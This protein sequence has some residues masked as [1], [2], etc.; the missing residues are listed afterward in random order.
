MIKSSV[1]VSQRTVFAVIWIPIL[2]YG[3]VLTVPAFV[4]VLGKHYGMSGAELGR[5]A[6]AEWLACIT[7]TYL[8][9]NRSIDELTRWVPWACVLAIAANVAGGILVSHVPLI[10]FHPLSTFGAGIAYGYVLKVFHA[11]GKQQRN[12]GIFLA[13]MYLSELGIFQLVNYLT[14]KYTNA[15][16]FI[17]YAALALVA[18]IVSLLT[19]ASLT[20]I[21]MPEDPLT[22]VKRQ[23][24]LSITILSSIGAL[25]ISYAAFGMMWPFVQLM[26]VTRGFSA[27]DV[28]N[29]TSAYAITGI[30]G[31]FSAA[32]LPLRV[33]RAVVL[34]IALCALLISI[35]MLYAG[36]S[37]ILFFIG[38]LIF[39]FY[40]T[41]YCTLHVGIIARADNT[42]RAIVLCGVSP[43]IGAIFGSFLGGLLI[44]GTNYLLPAR[45]GALLGVIGIAC[46][47][48]TMTR[49]KPVEALMPA[50]H[51]PS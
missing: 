42:G 5:L 35:Y 41:F 4:A 47:L 51:F 38:C 36:A 44:Q 15:A 34:G 8:T 50:A 11:S 3:A 43:S 21:A 22:G 1:Q 37:Y 10:L 19:R 14:D 26:G 2:A 29:G 16:V 27:L 25:G 48:A 40:W 31:A 24:R 32:L 23:S 28:T 39:G 17:V 33:N 49:M 30:L 20:N 18:L 45:V 12:F 6:S 46:T 7:G 9:K 13:T